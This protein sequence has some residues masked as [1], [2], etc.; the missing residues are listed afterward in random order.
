LAKAGPRPCGQVGPVKL[1]VVT[2]QS[3]AQLGQLV[4]LG[5]VG[6][7]LLLVAAVIQYLVAPLTLDQLNVGVVE[8]LVAPLAGVDNVGAAKRDVQ[9]SDFGVLVRL[10]CEMVNLTV[11]EWVTPFFKLVGVGKLKAWKPFPLLVRSERNSFAD[12][13]AI[14][15][16]P[17]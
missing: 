16:E 15:V 9:N 11:M 17:S 2:L 8:T 12:T 14:L 5:S 3:M 4:A 6:K 1:V 10:N 7:V 13:V